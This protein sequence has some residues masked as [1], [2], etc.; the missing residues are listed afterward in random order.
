MMFGL[1]T[2]EETFIL[3]GTSS[4]LSTLTN[5]GISGITR[6]FYNVNFKLSKNVFIVSS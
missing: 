2:A 3:K 1:E 4:F 5:T 6:L